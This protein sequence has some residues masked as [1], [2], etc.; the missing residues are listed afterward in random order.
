M[1]MPTLTPPYMLHLF[2]PPL[3]S[4]HHVLS[5]AN[6]TW[7]DRNGLKESGTQ[8]AM[9]AE[10]LGLRRNLRPS[11]FHL[12]WNILYRIPNNYTAYKTI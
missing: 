12:E 6:P 3:P 7:L 4:S 5:S 8:G 10:D 2:L 11:N 9:E 1:P